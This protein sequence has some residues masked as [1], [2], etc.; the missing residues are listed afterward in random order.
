MTISIDG[1]IVPRTLFPDNTVQV[2]KLPEAW[3]KRKWVNVVWDFE[4]AAELMELAQLKDLLDVNGVGAY[5]LINYLPYARQD[6]EVA[7]NATFALYPFSKLLNVLD[8]Y[9]VSIMDPHSPV[10]TRLI[11][12]SYE[13]YPFVEVNKAW[14]AVRAN[15][16]CYPDKGAAFKYTSKYPFDYINA[17]KTRN[18]ETGVIT[19]TKLHGRCEGQSVLIVDDICDGGRTFIE[20][21]KVLYQAGATEVSLFVTHGIFSQGLEPLR[22][23]GIARIF[24]KNGEEI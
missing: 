5:L 6:K 9:E 17:K 13:Q 14:A 2:W 22:A 15:V 19:G 4:D 20:L 23:A 12:A 16:A 18:Q 3:L 11:N 8:F 24:T 1:E 10:A 21:A 7:N